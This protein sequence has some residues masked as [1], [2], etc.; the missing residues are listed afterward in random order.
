[1][2]EGYEDPLK[3]PA[4]IVVFGLEVLKVVFYILFVV[5]FIPFFVSS[6]FFLSFSHFPLS[7][8]IDH[9]HSLTKVS[10]L[11]SLFALSFSYVLFFHMIHL[12]NLRPLSSK[13]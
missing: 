6:I 10:L 11:F 12:T 3:I 1:M 5:Y 13:T 2:D 4:V 9:A 8:R 7:L